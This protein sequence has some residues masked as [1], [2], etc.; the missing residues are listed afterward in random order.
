MR[1][2]NAE[3][4]GILARSEQHPDT[5][6]QNHKSCTHATQPHPLGTARPRWPSALAF[7]ISHVKAVSDFTALSVLIQSTTDS[8]AIPLPRRR[9]CNACGTARRARHRD[10]RPMVQSRAEIRKLVKNCRER[11]SAVAFESDCLHRHDRPECWR[12]RRLRRLSI[13]RGD[14]VE[15]DVGRLKDV[16]CDSRDRWQ[17]K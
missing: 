12:S 9:V 10:F 15:A 2:R 14:A 7:P 11:G 6:R 13:S 3:P 8:R 5:E 4:Q 16:D 1:A 17:D